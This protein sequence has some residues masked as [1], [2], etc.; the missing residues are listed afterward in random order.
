MHTSTFVCRCFQ[1]EWY[2]KEAKGELPNKVGTVP[3][4][5]LESEA[6]KEKLEFMEKELARAQEVAEF[7]V[8]LSNAFFCRLVYR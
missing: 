5:Y 4:V 8:T 3:D 1:T 6:L 2:E 7:S